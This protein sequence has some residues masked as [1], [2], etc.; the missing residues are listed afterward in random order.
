[1]PNTCL[2]VALEDGAGLSGPHPTE[3]CP[4]RSGL[5]LG[6]TSSVHLHWRLIG[7]GVDSVI[8]QGTR[9]SVPGLLPGQ[10]VM[11]SEFYLLLG[12]TCSLIWS[13]I[14]W[15]NGCTFLCAFLHTSNI[16]LNC[17]SFLWAPVPICYL[18]FLLRCVYLVPPWREHSLLAQRNG[19]QSRSDTAACYSSVNG[20]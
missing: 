1:M 8:S 2:P 17:F 15:I 10:K 13:Y 4:L 11:W 5:F 12:F 20:R 9:P 14:S 6:M 7:F 18:L 3:G 19:P 16:F